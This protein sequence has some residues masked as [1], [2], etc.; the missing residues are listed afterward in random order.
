MPSTS[1]EREGGVTRK[2]PHPD[3]VER[4]PVPSPRFRFVFLKRYLVAAYLSGLDIFLAWCQVRD[5][6]CGYG[7]DGHRP[8]ER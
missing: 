3:N 2:R 5:G 8:R 7:Y 6:G 4:C 1:V